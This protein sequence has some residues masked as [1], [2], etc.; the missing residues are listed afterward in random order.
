[1]PRPIDPDSLSGKIANAFDSAVDGNTLTFKTSAAKTAVDIGNTVR[2]AANRFRTRN[3]LTIKQFSVSRVAPRFTYRSELLITEAQAK[4]VE[5]FY[6]NLVGDSWIGTLIITEPEAVK[7][8]VH[9]Q[10]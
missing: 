10:G 5:A 4:E 1:M 9:K 3:K 6:Q 8:E 2:V 7:Y